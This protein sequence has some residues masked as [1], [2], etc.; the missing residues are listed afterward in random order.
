MAGQATE[1]GISLKQIGEEYTVRDAILPSLSGVEIT[2]WQSSFPELQAALAT[3]GQ[4]MDIFSYVML[5]IVA[6][7]ILNLLL[8]AVFERTREIGVLGALGLR[9][10]QISLLFLLEGI[11]MGLVGVA[12]GVAIGLASNFAIGQVGIDYSAFSSMTSFTALISD[13]VYSTLGTEKLLTRTLVVMIFALLASLYPSSTAA[14][15]EPAKSLH[16]V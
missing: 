14:Q 6:I 5:L 15:Q 12:F 7:G 9:P 16:Y 1:I 4:A 8:M 13:R 2:S 3:K 11:L 10:G